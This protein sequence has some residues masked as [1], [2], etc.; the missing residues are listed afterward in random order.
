M[1]DVCLCL[2]MGHSLPMLPRL[3]SNTV[4]LRCSQGRSLPA[5]TW[6]EMRPYTLEAADGKLL[7]AKVLMLLVH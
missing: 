6:G 4:F 2:F 1:V 5:R 3:A 7:V